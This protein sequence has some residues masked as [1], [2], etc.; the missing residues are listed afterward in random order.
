MRV[1]IRQSFLC[2]CQDFII[3]YIVRTDCRQIFSRWR[4]PSTFHFFQ[5]VPMNAMERIR[6]AYRFLQIKLYGP[7]PPTA[8]IRPFPRPFSTDIS[9]NTT[10]KRKR[11]SSFEEDG[12]PPVIVKR[13]RPTFCRSTKD[14]ALRLEKLVSGLQRLERAEQTKRTLGELITE[15]ALNEEDGI[16]TDA[17]N[18]D[19]LLSQQVALQ[20]TITDEFNELANHANHLLDS[21]EDRS[22]NPLPRPLIAQLKR[23]DDACYAFKSQ[24]ISEE[25]E[26]DK[27]DVL[28]TINGS[29]FQ[30]E[31]RTSNRGWIPTQCSLPPF[32]PQMY[33]RL[34]YDI[35]SISDNLESSQSGNH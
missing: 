17:T 14:Y 16:A 33:L 18:L 28:K 35:C 13:V 9:R 22:K 12:E 23:Y 20:Q 3:A 2:H 30:A 7:T 24:R 25:H 29:L 26:K 21:I 1:P 10:R 34:T 31:N 19:D 5:Q 6:Q 27:D 8:V 4:K 32:P 15:H 11:R